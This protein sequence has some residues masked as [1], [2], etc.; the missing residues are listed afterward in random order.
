MPPPNVGA[1][2]GTIGTHAFS[3][4]IDEVLA[5]PAC[6]G[7]LT[8]NDPT[9]LVCEGCGAVYPVDDGIPIFRDSGSGDQESERRFRDRVATEYAECDPRELLEIVER[10][11]CISA[12]RWRSAR[13]ARGFASEDWLLD[14]GIG[15]GWHWLGHAEGA[16]V[17]GIDMSIGNL[18]LARRLLGDEA[19]SVVL[20]CADAAALPL[21]RRSMAGLWSVQVFQH[22][23]DDV[24]A[25]AKA[26]LDRV[27]TGR[28]RMEISNLNPALLHR[29][30]YRLTGR[31]LHRRGRI[32]EM[33]L[34]RRSAREWA[35]VWS[36]FRRGRCRMSVG[37]SELFFHPD[38]RLRPRPY[39][40]R[41][42][43]VLAGVPALAGMIARQIDVRV[44]SGNGR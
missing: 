5:C 11:H 2:R 24:L 20:V 34:V 7:H 35:G 3:H 29:V 25:R 43:R 10:H 13:F 36:D 23:P 18:R 15:W 19:D 4:A 21:R 39:P 14:V 41:L 38:L 26:E 27:L 9:R 37:Y 28:F 6:I 32:G 33:E 44:E 16:R 12:M 1:D 30:V 42:E 31:R 40:L 17:L 22:M 8:C